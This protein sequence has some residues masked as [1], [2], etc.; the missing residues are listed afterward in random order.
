MKLLK[1]KMM[2][3]IKD[4]GM[5]SVIAK[6][7]DAES[8]QNKEFALRF[9][10]CSNKIEMVTLMVLVIGNNKLWKKFSD[11]KLA[12]QL[13]ELSIIDREKYPELHHEIVALQ[14]QIENLRDYLLS[15]YQRNSNDHQAD[16]ACCEH[17]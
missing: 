1:K 14:K 4:T 10:K 15:I 16:D 6:I 13:D 8:E 12:K 17:H 5:H 11:D 9:A 2:N 3:G 7:F